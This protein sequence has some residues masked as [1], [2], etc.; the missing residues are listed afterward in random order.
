MAI[1]LDDPSIQLRARQKGF[2]TRGIR[3]HPA[4]L[5][6][7]DLKGKTQNLW[8]YKT[9]FFCLLSPHGQHLSMGAQTEKTIWMMENF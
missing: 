2:F 7:V 8:E 3:P 1:D 5:L 9:D 4:T 6:Y